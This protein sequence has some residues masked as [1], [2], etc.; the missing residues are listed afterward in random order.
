DGRDLTTNAVDDWTDKGNTELELGLTIR[1]LAHLVS[2]DS[3]A[4]NAA[5]SAV[6]RAKLANKAQVE[7][8]PKLAK[9]RPS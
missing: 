3:D 8:S 2:T 6:E 5:K 1:N 4:M 7:A 9:F